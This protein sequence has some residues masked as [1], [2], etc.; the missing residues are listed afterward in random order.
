MSLTTSKFIIFRPIVRWWFAE[1][2][3]AL[4]LVCASEFVP[5]QQK[6]LL[7]LKNIA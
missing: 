6:M 3:S 4:L 7:S 5:V 1:F 2:Y